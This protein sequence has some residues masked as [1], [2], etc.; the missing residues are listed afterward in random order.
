MDTIVAVCLVLIVLELLVALIFFVT[1]ILQLRQTARAVEVLT[2]R[3]D[4]EVDHVSTVMKS[5][6]MQ[7][8]SAVGSVVAGFW[9]G[10]KG[11]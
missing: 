9:A 7:S 6:W 1:M 3:V 2:Y 10:R 4:E 5:G 11:Q 8:L